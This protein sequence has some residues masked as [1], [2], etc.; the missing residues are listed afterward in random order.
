[1]GEC[2]CY[3]MK[4]TRTGALEYRGV[5]NV[6]MIGERKG[7]AN[8]YEFDLLASVVETS[9]FLDLPEQDDG[10]AITTVGNT[11]IGVTFFDGRERVFKRDA[12]NEPPIFWA[13]AR[14]IETLLEKA[15]WGDDAYHQAPIQFAAER[16]Q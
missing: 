15:K 2:P 13:V 5:A 6:E 8:Y 16:D 9:G 3:S 12:M 1:L 10:E 7:S 11:T 4:A 14:L